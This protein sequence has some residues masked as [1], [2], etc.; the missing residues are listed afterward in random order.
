[1]FI[2]IFDG[3]SSLVFDDLFQLKEYLYSLCINDWPQTVIE[4]DTHERK[5]KAVMPYYDGRSIQFHT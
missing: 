1:M 4:V 2:A 3:D 5:A